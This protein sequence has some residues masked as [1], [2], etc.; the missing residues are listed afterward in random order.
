[1]A[2]LAGTR[3]LDLT[4]LIPGPLASLFLTD[5][6]ADV[7]K[8]EDPQPGDYLRGIN[9]ALFASLNRGKRS[10]R[11]NLKASGGPALLVRLCRSADVLLDGFRPGVLDRLG[12]GP[13]VLLEANPRLVV[14]SLTGYGQT[15]PYRDRAG[16][17]IGYLALSGV[18]GK[19]GADVPGV[20]LADVAGAQMAVAAI[21][22]ALLERER[23]GRGQHL[24]VAL[25]EAAMTFANYAGGELLTGDYPCYAVYATRDGGHLAVGA[26][27]PK[28]WAAFCAAIG[29]PELESRSFDAEA[30][31]IVA[32]KI[33]ERTRAEWETIFA[34]VDCCVEPVLAAREINVHPQHAARDLFATSPSGASQ[35]TPLFR[36]PIAEL[37]CAPAPALGEQTDAILIEAGLSKAERDAL[38]LGG[39]C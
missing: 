35:R 36:G 12:C 11:L 29:M 1:M 20:Q 14:C 7:I 13:R 24:D 8:V 15:G 2:A 21:L 19:N 26:L 28:F 5:L 6:G 34:G 4:R 22:A 18:L 9:G 23:T 16:H 37:P 3:V 17:D 31:T 27:E 25:T 32:K 30:R 10:L 33:S 38:S 39:V